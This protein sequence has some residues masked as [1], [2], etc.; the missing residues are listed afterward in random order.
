LSLTISGDANLFYTECLKAADMYGTDCD[1]AAVNI[2]VGSLYT[3]IKVITHFL[4]LILLFCSR[5]QGD[6]NLWVLSI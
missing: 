6:I 1:K 3:N 5:K 2:A 4:W